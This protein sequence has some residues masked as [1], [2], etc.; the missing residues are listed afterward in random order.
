MI[1]KRQATE[2]SF[3]NKFPEHYFYPDRNSHLTFKKSKL[4]GEC[5]EEFEYMSLVTTGNKSNLQN[6][7]ISHRDREIHYHF[8]EPAKS[9]AHPILL[10]GGVLQNRKSWK[11]YIDDLSSTNS[12]LVIDL[13]G[14]GDAKILDASYGFDFLADCV[15]AVIDHL[16]LKKINIFSTSYSSII[17]YEFSDRYPSLID[18]LVISSSMAFLPEQ[19]RKVMFNCIDSLEQKNL[20]KFYTVFIDGVCNSSKNVP[21]YD[22]SRKVI[23][24]LTQKLTEEEIGQFI[25]N[26]KRVLQYTVPEVKPDKIPL[27]PLIFT[28]EYD[29]F[30]PPSLCREIGQFYTSSYFGTIDNYDH[31][32]HIG[33]RQIIIKSILPF[34]QQHSI[35]AFC[36]KHENVNAELQKDDLFDKEEQLNILPAAVNLPVLNYNDYF[37]RGAV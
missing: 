31:L 8:I 24:M 14:I 22:L 2:K 15:Y 28:G 16:R 33:N 1:N 3:V 7:T 34:F 30:T 21:N 20:S 29:T 36:T 9:I 18:K 35:P 27:I 26:T 5:Q 12:V 23:E 25:E 17:A 11:S 10:L 6:G 37:L 4:F 19:Q 13:P 32:F